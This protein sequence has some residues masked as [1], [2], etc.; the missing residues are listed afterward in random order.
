MNKQTQVKAEDFI[1]LPKHK[2]QDVAEMKNLIFRLIRI[3]DEPYLPYPDEFYAE[4]ICVE[5]DNGR[6]TKAMIG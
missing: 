6:V 2:A 3:D 1:G 4:R 5:I